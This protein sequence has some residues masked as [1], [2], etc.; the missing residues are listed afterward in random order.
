MPSSPALNPSHSYTPH[1]L[2]G[3]RFVRVVFFASLPEL[4]PTVNPCANLQSGASGRPWATLLCP[5]SISW[6]LINVGIAD[7]AAHTR[8]V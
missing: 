2:S 6:A 7:P 1:L 8:K 4:T 3:D 5:E